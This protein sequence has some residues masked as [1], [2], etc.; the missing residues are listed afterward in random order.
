VEA[1]EETRA[2]LE[3]ASRLY[4]PFSCPA[5]AECCHLAVTTRPPWLWPTEW[6]VL[7]EALPSI[8]PPRP[9][10]GCRLLDAAGLRCTAYDARPFGCR[11]F[12]CEKRRGPVNEP[13]ARTHALLDELRSL[14]VAL[15]P[16]AAPRPIDEWFEA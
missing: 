3:Q 6:A 16:L 11:T 2:V 9:G 15:D 5:T 8:P 10:G 4:E 12:F 13:T 1:A 7:R 14:N